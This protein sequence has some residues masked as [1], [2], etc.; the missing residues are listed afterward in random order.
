MK[1]YDFIKCPY[2]CGSGWYPMLDELFSQIKNIVD[3]RGK[4]EFEFE[5]TQI[6][7]KFGQLRVYTSFYAEEIEDLIDKY[8]EKSAHIC[9]VCGDVGELKIE[10]GWY[11]TVCDKHHKEWINNGNARSLS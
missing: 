10:G 5:V 8:S 2:E 9:E 1:K 7:E 3:T 11:K 6:K 4:Q